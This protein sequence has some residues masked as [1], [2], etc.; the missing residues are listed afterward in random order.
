MDGNGQ[1]AAGRFAR[2]GG[3]LAIARSLFPEIAQPWLD[4]ST[5]INPRSYP[6]PRASH[7]ARNRLPETAE[8]AR[9]EALAAAAFG[10]DDPARVVATAGSECALRLLPQIVSPRAAVVVG[11][12]YSSHADAWTGSGALT[13][14]IVHDELPAHAQRA[15]CLTI[16]NPNNPDGRIVERAQ[17][18]ALHDTLSQHGGMLIVD[19]AFA[20]VVPQVSVAAEAGAAVAPRLV[21]LR[22]FGKFFGLAGLRLG[23]VIAPQ[24]LA[25]SLR[26]LIG[27]WPVSSD[28]LA[29]GLA[30]YAD[31]P[32]AERECVTLHRSAQRLD[33]LLERSGVEL[34][35]GTSLFR[36]ARA[37]DAHERFARLLAAGILV[38][39]FDFD[40]SLLR[41]GLPRGRDQWRR[42]AAALGTNT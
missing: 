36:L 41:F 31:Q 24:P 7:R 14:T 1:I 40:P 4:L 28:A 2:H 5:G 15:V 21:V 19:E 27:D 11:P 29:A 23:F 8:L 25:A 34:M 35:G 33:R 6:A 20:D 3:R 16:V 10:V 9:L 38:R 17:L 30:A 18:L 13:Q 26:G 37:S 12:T 39:P 42:L 32:W 22:S